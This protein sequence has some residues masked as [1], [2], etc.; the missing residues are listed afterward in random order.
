M[1]FTQRSV[2]LLLC[3]S[4]VSF[5]L[6][7][8]YVCLLLCDSYVCLL[9]CDRYVCLLLCDRYVCLLLS[10]RYMRLLL[11]DRYL[12]RVI[13]HDAQSHVRYHFLCNKWLATDYG[14]SSLHERFHVMSKE[15]LETF[16][17]M[18]NMSTDRYVIHS[19]MLYQ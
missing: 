3:D 11:C 15:E 2:C 12:C 8:R 13:V 1:L 10:D 17:C 6:C 4:Y 5:L 9:L 16:S 14:G 7:D 18:V 19:F